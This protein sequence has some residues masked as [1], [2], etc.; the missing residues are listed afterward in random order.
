MVKVSVIMPVHNA[1]P[2]L[3][4]A[5]ESI[6]SQ[7]FQDFEFMIIDDGSTDGSQDVIRSLS[8]GR[9]KFVQNNRNCGVAATLNK[10]LD[11]ALGDYVARMD[12]DDVSRP[13]RLQSQLLLMEKKSNLGICGAWV[14]TC[15]SQGKGHVIRPPSDSETLRSFII[16]NNPVIHPVVM[17]RRSMLEKY[18]LRYDQSCLAAQDYEFWARCLHYFDFENIKRVLLTYRVNESG[19][20]HRN[21][22]HSNNIAINIQ[23]IELLRLGIKAEKEELEL[24]RAVGNSTG[25]GSL[26]GVVKAREWLERLLFCNETV[27]CYPVKGLKRAAAQVWFH[28]CSNSSGIGPAVL[29]EFY[30]ASFSRYYMPSIAHIAF[31]L[32]NPMIR[33]RKAPVGEFL[34]HK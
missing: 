21:F 11:M 30:R 2:Y 34:G 17:M 33:I 5:V 4:N 15:N 26:E 12:A 13:D 19:M 24:H 32:L 9:I 31:L 25:V 14:K 18:K 22:N 20:T 1:G 6:L 7:T 10:G 3:Q 8:D 27:H 16:F 28:L 23:K 29:K